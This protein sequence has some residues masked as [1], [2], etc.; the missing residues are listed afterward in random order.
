MADTTKAYNKLFGT[1]ELGPEHHSEL[2]STI[3]MTI[4]QLFPLLNMIYT[5]ALTFAQIILVALLLLIMIQTQEWRIIVQRWMCYFPN[6][7]RPAGLRLL[8]LPEEGMIRHRPGRDMIEHEEKRA[9]A[10]KGKVN[11]RRNLKRS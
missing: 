1:I 4:R 7:P 9:K 3:T 5:M 2:V 8:R 11:H 6:T 10:R